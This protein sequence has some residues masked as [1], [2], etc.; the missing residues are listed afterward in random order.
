MDNEERTTLTMTVPRHRTGTFRNKSHKLEFWNENSTSTLPALAAAADVTMT[1][2]T[3]HLVNLG[4]TKVRDD[5]GC[6]RLNPVNFFCT[7]KNN[8]SKFF[9]L[10]GNLQN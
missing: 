1:L 10:L 2:T 5:G 4:S 7:K 3:S 6:I 8:H 9:L